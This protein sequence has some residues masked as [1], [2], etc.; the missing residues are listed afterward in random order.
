MTG[1]TH[2]ATR[3]AIVPPYL[4]VRLARVDDPRLAAAAEAA[5]RS[6]MR[7]TPIRDLRAAKHPSPPRPGVSGAAP[8]RGRLD[9][10]VSDAGSLERLPGRLVRREGQPPGADP[11]VTEAWEGLGDTH[12]LFWNVF[13]RDSI[14]DRGLTLEATVHY[15]RNYDNAFWDGERMVFGD[16][17]GQVFNRFTSSVTVI[18]HELTHGVTQFTADLAYEGQSGA[19]NESLSDVF[20]SLVEQ[21]ARG[22]SAAEAGWLIG[23]GLFTDQ[24]QGV[25]LRS[26]KAP[27]TAY[28]DDVLG[29]DPQPAHLSGYIETE[30]DNGGVHLNSGIPN[31]AFY[32]VA[33]ALGGNAW[34]TAGR[35]WFDTLTSGTLPRTVDFAGFARAT[36][37]AAVTR[38]GAGSRE[39]DAV[40]AGWSE[41]GLGGGLGAGWGTRSA[42][43]PGSSPVAGRAFVDPGIRPE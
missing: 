17:D 22:Q 25:A 20:G 1:S 38:Y 40:I 35:I 30:D 16:G 8:V 13:E 28:N 4:L 36:S 23:E 33:T 24:V 14:D 18:G 2:K 5:R 3:C 42:S 7:D 19:I 10:A 32:L 12:S 9:R 43:R 15:G 11:A 37:R 27:G 41:V 31:R 26:L 39:H 34:D 6:L 21:H 29:K